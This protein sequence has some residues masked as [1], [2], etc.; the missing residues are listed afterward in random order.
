MSKQRRRRREEQRRLIQ[1]WN[2]SDD[3]AAAYAARIGVASNTLYRWRS[4]MTDAG[5]KVPE[6][7]LSRIVEVRAA[8]MPADT[9]FEIEVGGR[10][11]RVP[12]SFDE[13]GLRRL[14]R[15]LEAAP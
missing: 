6:R 10:R 12:E 5:P 8:V 15:V 11:I 13:T 4:A 2:D 9:R 14:L 3:S 1:E 7:A